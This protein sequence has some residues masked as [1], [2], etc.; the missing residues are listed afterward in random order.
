[1]CAVMQAAYAASASLAP[2]SMQVVDEH[3]LLERQMADIA[4]LHGEHPA[5]QP[6]SAPGLNQHMPRILPCIAAL[7]GRSCQPAEGAL[8]W[9]SS[10]EVTS[11]HLK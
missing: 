5:F 1:M 10:A 3:E 11:R 7:R 4:L 6:A 2:T 9:C 8:A